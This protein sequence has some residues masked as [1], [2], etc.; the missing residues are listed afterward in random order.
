[1][2]DTGEK[3][4]IIHVKEVTFLFCQYCGG[5]VVQIAETQ[6]SHSFSCSGGSYYTI[7]FQCRKCD[8]VFEKKISSDN[9]DQE[10][11]NTFRLYEGHY[12]VEKIIEGATKKFGSF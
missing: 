9:E 10:E 6:P 12:T 11:N 2:E 1:M 8:K 5:T 3:E 7:Y 4:E